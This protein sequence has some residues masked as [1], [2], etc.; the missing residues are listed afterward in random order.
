MMFDKENKLRDRA[1]ADGQGDDGP[2][3]HVHVRHVNENGEVEM[4]KV[5]KVCFRMQ[6]SLA[7]FCLRE[8]WQA[9]LDLTDIENKE[10]RYVL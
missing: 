6:L 7:C 4:R 3:D 8:A 2:L 1:E 10:F 5:D 9:F